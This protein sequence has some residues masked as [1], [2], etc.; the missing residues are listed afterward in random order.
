MARASPYDPGP[1]F[2]RERETFA[3]RFPHVASV[4]LA[5]KRFRRHHTRDCAMYDPRAHTIYFH[6]DVVDA[7]SAPQWTALI[8][9]ELAHA[10]NPE[11]S[12]ADTDKLAE[13]VTGQRIYY[14]DDI[15]TT[16]PGARPRPKHL[17]K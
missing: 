9:H 8:R 7:L 12:E 2:L 4:K 1:L 11:L 17:P 16:L 13:A 6:P 10:A 5:Y 3:R 14:D 15:Q